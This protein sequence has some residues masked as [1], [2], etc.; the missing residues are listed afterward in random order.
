V[1]LLG[2][3]GDCWFLSALAALSE[4]PQLIRGDLFPE[5]SRES[6]DYGC[7]TLRFCKMGLWQTVRVD[8]YFPCIPGAGPIYSRSNGNELWVLLAEKAFAKVHGS[9]DAIRAGFCYEAMMDLTGAPTISIRF[10][11]VETKKKVRIS[12][13]SYKIELNCFF[14]IF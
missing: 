14:V 2:S 6:N 7:Y 1:N 13:S 9:Y 10:D 8:D 12:F 5:N 11:F 4:F 3:L